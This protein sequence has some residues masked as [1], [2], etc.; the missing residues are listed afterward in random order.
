[1]GLLELVVRGRGGRVVGDG[2]R[3]DGRVA[4]GKRCHGGL[5][6]LLGARDVHADDPLGHLERRGAG[7]ERHLGPATG[8]GGGDGIA[9]LAGRGV[10]DVAHGVNGLVRGSR[11]DEDPG[12]LEVLLHTRGVEGGQ[13][14]RDDVLNVGELARTHV[15]AGEAPLH[16]KHKADAAGPERPQVCLGCGVLPHV[17]VHAGRHQHGAGDGQKRG[18]KAVVGKPRGHLGHDVGRGGHHHHEVGPLREVH[19]RDGG[20][21]VAV[22]VVCHGV[23][24]EALEGGGPHE[25]LRVGRHGDAHLAACLLQAAQHLARLVG[26]NAAADG[27]KDVPGLR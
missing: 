12:E 14:R 20:L 18:A 8:R 3:A 5:V 4:P 25:A 21:G 27:E 26:G 19:V 17:D 22:E 1:M 23:P 9:H 10:G 15:S 16:R 13:G 2:S 24:G 6:H 7:D 11:G